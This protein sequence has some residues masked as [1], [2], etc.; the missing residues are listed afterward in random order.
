M[1]SLLS[2]RGPSSGGSFDA[3]GDPSQQAVVG[4]HL[5]IDLY[6]CTPDRLSDEFRVVEC[7]E[8]AA[9]AAGCVVLGRL[10]HRFQPQGVA[11]VVLLAESHASVHTWPEHRFAAVDLFFC[12]ARVDEA[13]G[14][15]RLLE[16]F[17]PS[18]HSIRISGRGMI[19]ALSDC[20][21]EP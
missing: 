3:A 5:L 2:Q 8:Q 13:A 17:K 21:G 12:G 18:N 19:E 10:S 6:G 16:F 15:A 9:L 14:V 11:A 20:G 4:R 7:L 1:T